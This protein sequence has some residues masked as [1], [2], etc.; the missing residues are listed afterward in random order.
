MSCA[1]C[2]RHVEDALDSVDGTWARVDLGNG[3]AHVLSKRPIDADAYAAAVSD[4][5]YR[6]VP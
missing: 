6:L 5:G 1:G 3:T 4:A 2:A